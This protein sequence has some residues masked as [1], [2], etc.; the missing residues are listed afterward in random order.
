MSNRYILTG[1]PGAGKTVLIRQLE[2]DGYSV[3]EEAATDVIALLHAQGIEEPWRDP[4][5]TERIA[6]LQEQRLAAAAPATGPQ[7]HDRS[8][9]CTY[10][11]ALYLDHPIPPILEAAVARAIAESLFNRRVFFVRLL[12]FIIPTE[13]RRISLEQSQ[14]FDLVH[15]QVYRDFGFDLIPI[16]PGAIAERT[17]AIIAAATQPQT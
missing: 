17:A 16:E 6:V 8:V 9:F 11:L 7:F 15:Q 10:A 12:G 4:A 1:A 2:C 14:R 3:V 13:A 5:F